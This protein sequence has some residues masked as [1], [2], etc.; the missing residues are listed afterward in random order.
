MYK[1]QNPLLR[2]LKNIKIPSQNNSEIIFNKKFN[3]YAEHIVLE[4]YYVR[5]RIIQCE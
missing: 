1:V 2:C 4:I 5:M 3:I